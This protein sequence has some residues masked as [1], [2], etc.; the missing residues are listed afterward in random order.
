MS[1]NERRITSLGLHPGHESGE[2]V[3]Y[4]GIQTAIFL[5]QC[6]FSKFSSFCFALSLCGENK[7]K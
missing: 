7:V 1:W 3:D 6:L 2:L 4:D 5:L